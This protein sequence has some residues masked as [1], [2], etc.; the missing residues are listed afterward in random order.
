MIETI[1][2]FSVVNKSSFTYL[3]KSVAPH[4]LFKNSLYQFWLF[5]TASTGLSLST[6]QKALVDVEDRS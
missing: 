3:F 1:C 6:Q 4:L 2:N 5:G